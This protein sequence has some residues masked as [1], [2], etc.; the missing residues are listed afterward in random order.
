MGMMQKSEHG[1][2]V[3]QTMQS[4]RQHVTHATPGPRQ[5]PG[6]MAAPPTVVSPRI[7]LPQHRIQ[8]LGQVVLP[9][10]KVY[11]NSAH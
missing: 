1:T 6:V 7:Q 2:Q 8:I 10:H 11:R 3:G 4:E 9:C 5:L